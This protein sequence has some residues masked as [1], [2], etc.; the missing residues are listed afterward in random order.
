MSTNAYNNMMRDFVNMANAANR[1]HAHAS[2]DYA[3]NGGSSVA[4]RTGAEILKQR[5]A[6]RTA[7]LPINAWVDGDVFFVS[8]NLPG[9]N[10]ED[11]EI[12]FESDE[13]TIRGEYPAVEVGGAEKETENGSEDDAAESKSPKIQFIRHE[14]YSGP[15]ERKIGFNVPINVEEIEATFENG[16]LKLSVPKAEEAKP[17]Q[18]KVLAK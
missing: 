5:S 13:L 15:F 17:K 6:K 18:I 7:T 16:T 14:L 3:R 2:Y 1:S 10:P 9:V 8:A 4:A 12:T 11:V